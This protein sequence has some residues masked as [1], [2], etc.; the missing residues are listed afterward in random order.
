MS[1]DEVVASDITRV[2]YLPSSVPASISSP[3]YRTASQ[4][5]ISTSG[6]PLTLTPF[7]DSTTFRSFIYQ[8]W[9][10]IAET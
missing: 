9:L 7:H 1:Y 3:R 6:F 2:T 5:S 10:L 8:S 4:I